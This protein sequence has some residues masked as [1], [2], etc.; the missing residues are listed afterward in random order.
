VIFQPGQRV[1]Y[2]SAYGRI[3]N[4]TRRPAVIRGV[5]VRRVNSDFSDV[6]VA[7]KKPL[8]VRTSRLRLRPIGQCGDGEAA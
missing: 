8:L 1:E 4:P 3:T 7:G 2:D 6:A 5:Y